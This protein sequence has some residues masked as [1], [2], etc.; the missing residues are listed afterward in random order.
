M[1]EPLQLFTDAIALQNEG[2][3]AEA[4][5]KYDEFLLSY[6]GSAQMHTNRGLAL[7]EL[8]RTGEAIA[9]YR[10][11]V[12]C[13]AGYFDAHYSMGLALFVE[14][15]Y[16]DAL[17]SFDG[18][19]AIAPSADAYVSRGSTHMELGQYESA[20]D[21]YDAALRINPNFAKAHMNKGSALYEMER[22]S[23]AQACYEQAL[24][25]HPSDHNT[26]WNEALCLL[27]AGNLRRGWPLYERRLEGSLSQ[28]LRRAA[29]GKP[30]FSGLATADRLAGKTIL[31]WPE[32]GHGDVM[33]FCRYAHELERLGATVILEVY[34]PL[35]RLL[36]T[37]FAN[38]DIRVALDG[39]VSPSEFDFHLPLLSL[40]LIC[41][42][43]SL[44]NIPTRTTYLFA[45]PQE[46]QAWQERLTN[47]GL[48]QGF[49]MGLVWAGGHRP[50][51]P[52]DAKVDAA[53]SL[54]LEAF[55][56]L[57]ALSQT[58]DVQFFS[59]QL[60]EPARQ[61]EGMQGLPIIDLTA[62]VHDWADTAAL[63]ANLD[64]VISC[65]TAVAHLAAAMG[66]PTWLL[67]RFNGCWRWLQ[68]GDDSPWYP[69]VRL[70]RQ[71]TRGDWEGVM[72]HVTTGLTT[73][74]QNASIMT[75]I[76]INRGLALWQLQRFNEAIASYGRAIACD[77]QNAIAYNERGNAHYALGQNEQA[78]LDFDAALAIHPD[79]R[80]AR[81]NRAALLLRF[82]RYQEAS[83]DVDHLLTLGSADA[84]TH[85]NHALA[86]QACN[87]YALAIASYEHCLQL[88][89]GNVNALWNESQC[90]LALGDYANGWRKFE[91]RWQSAN[92]KPYQR[93]YTQSLWLG[94]E[95]LVGKTILLWPDQGFG[96]VMQFCRYARL[97]QQ[98]GATVLL[99]TS[100]PLW[101]LFVQ[102]FAGTGVVVVPDGEHV[103]FDFHAPLMSLP[104]ACGTDSVER[105]PALHPYLF[106]TPVNV[107]Q[108]SV[109]QGLRVGLVWAGG[110]R[111]HQPELKSVDAA[112]SLKFSQF[113]PLAALTQIK[114]MQFFSLQLGEPAKQ[115]EDVQDF[116]IIDL[117]ADLHDWAETAALVAG[118]DLVISCDTA[119]AHLA[120]AMG[121]PT[122]I[123]SRF[124]G[125]W[126]WLQDRDDSPWYP[127][128]RLF[129]QK[130][131]GDWE[132]VI[133]EVAL[134]LD[135]YNG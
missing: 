121:K 74:L 113:A 30:R 130:T 103:E 128:V 59:L 125:C 73:V 95:P 124:N 37:S 111:P 94:Q 54:R 55:A 56:P 117:T 80:I 101:R 79:L 110:Y 38:T 9:A 8:G 46:A 57:V 106:A 89:P 21:D 77:P 13:D 34:P 99:A 60:G 26:E 70:F 71:T 47:Q 18:A 3:F 123:L 33:Q 134:A 63:I 98:R 65:D 42:T 66:K 12:L 14:R 45:V 116:P 15:R 100:P 127:T 104:L 108:P 11:A 119:V 39:T 105:I 115:M 35:L 4:V 64:L 68:G 81:H 50:H 96:D 29:Y 7:F 49:R 67:A 6:V 92:L 43:D 97:V 2:R 17:M 93:R 27:R 31:L 91:W 83:N 76:H 132:S 25:L 102:S 88:D 122:W 84:T 129:R 10:E 112:R 126:R 61:L 1:S 16:L 135:S 85:Y 69:T 86:R 48:H 20:L 23:E 51:Q 78:L 118:L 120:A 87:Q 114:G 62:D 133:A 107:P 5:D 36:E 19:M 75:A 24:L 41:G 28:P 82:E 52:I 131:Q 53:R 32:Q 44:D 22:L 109:H 72:A 90:R 40:P 58:M